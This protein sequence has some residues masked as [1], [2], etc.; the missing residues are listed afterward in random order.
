MKFKE[1]EKFNKLTKEISELHNSFDFLS[2]TSQLIV[3]DYLE[4]KYKELEV[5]LQK[6]RD[7]LSSTVEKIKN[8]EEK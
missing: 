4:D 5:V 3:A 8:I 6:S 2:V 7:E 1:F